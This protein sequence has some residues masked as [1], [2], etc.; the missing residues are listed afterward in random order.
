M[1]HGRGRGTRL[2][3]PTANLAIVAPLPAGIYAATVVVGNQT[4]PAAGYIHPAEPTILEVHLLNWHENLYDVTITVELRY[5]LRAH[6][7]FLSAQAL[8][9]QIYQDI[10]QVQQCLQV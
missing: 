7:E 1:K 10:A 8:I 9:A 5:W 6:R 3:F 4:V 2:G